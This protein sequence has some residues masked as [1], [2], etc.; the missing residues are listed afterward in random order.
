M[1]NVLIILISSFLF[2]AT[3]CAPRTGTKVVYVK[4]RP[5]TY[6]VVKVRGKQYYKWNGKHYRK[7][8][9]GYVVTRI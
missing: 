4:K 5:A 2:F 7:T 9:R 8:K 1:R 6:K 3:S